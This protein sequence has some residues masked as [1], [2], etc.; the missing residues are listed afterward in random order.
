MNKIIHAT[1][2]TKH[3]L[4]SLS[5]RLLAPKSQ[6]QNLVKLRFCCN[7]LYTKSHPYIDMKLCHLKKLRLPNLL[8]FEWMAID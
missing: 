6:V 3:Q 5:A 2:S 1:Q 7:V 8:R 4:T